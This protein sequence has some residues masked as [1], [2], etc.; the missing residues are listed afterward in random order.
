[1]KKIPENG[2]TIPNWFIIEKECELEVTELPKI[3]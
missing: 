2:D 1:M 3:Y